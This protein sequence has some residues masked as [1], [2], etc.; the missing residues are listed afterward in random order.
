MGWPPEKD[1]PEVQRTRIRE[2]A[3]SVY[4]N[5]TVVFDESWVGGRIIKIRIDDAESGKMIAG[6]SGE[7]TSSEIADMSDHE[8]KQMLQSLPQKSCPDPRGCRKK[9]PHSSGTSSRT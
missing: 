2:L 4:P 6:P 7:Y 8:L 3:R 1:K 9:P 5:G